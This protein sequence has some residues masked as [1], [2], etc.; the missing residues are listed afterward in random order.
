MQRKKREHRDN[1][2]RHLE[3]LDS[4][5][6]TEYWRFWKS[7]QNRTTQSDVI[8]ASTFAGHYK[9]NDSPPIYPD[10]NYANINEIK[11]FIMRYDA[12]DDMDIDDKYNDILNAPISKSEIHN[13]I[14]QLKPGKACGVDGI[15]S[16]CLCY[17]ADNLD[18]PLMAL[19][20]YVFDNGE[21]P[22]EWA[23]GIINPIHKKGPLYS[24]TIIE[25]LLSWMLLVNYLK[26]F[27][28]PDSIICDKSANR[29]I[30]FRT[31]LRIVAV[32]LIMILY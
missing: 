27:G 1:V 23:E 9:A 3:D 24:L 14:R 13:A 22:D 32:P 10:F 19:F 30:P 21:Y 8:D 15:P 18:S 16:E 25:K 28:T 26:L 17:A 7:L 4:N 12:T 5:D 11:N 20:S 6:T 31:V 2:L 29:K